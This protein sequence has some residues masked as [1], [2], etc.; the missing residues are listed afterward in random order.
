MRRAALAASLAVSFVALG[1]VAA[2]AGC[3]AASPPVDLSGTWPAKPGDYEEVTEAWTRRDEHR[4]DFSMVVD[5]AATVKAPPWRAAYVAH[6]ARREKLSPAAVAALEAAE[7]TADAEFLE[8]EL[9]M[10]TYDRRA[11]DLTKGE[12][13]IWRVTLTGDDGAEV[14]PVEIQRDRRP[15]SEVK[16]YFPALG[17]F[18]VPYIVKFP[19]TGALL[20]EGAKRLTLRVASAQGAVELTWTDP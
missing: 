4:R 7:R 5:V 8:L 3:G 14:A 19:R 13:S 12:R 15:A 17:D 11:N 10:A 9:M 1:A 6:R 16:A 20:H 18:H 2:L